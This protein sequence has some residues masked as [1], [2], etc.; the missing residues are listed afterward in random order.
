MLILK[1]LLFVFTVFSVVS[2]V[3]LPTLEAAFSYIESK[4]NSTSGT[5]STTGWWNSANVQ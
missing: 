2:A 5:Y 3:D 1:H 4:F